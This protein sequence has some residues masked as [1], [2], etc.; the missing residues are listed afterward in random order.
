TRRITAD[1][2]HQRLAINGPNDEVRQ[3]GE[4]IDELLERLE[5]SFAAQ[6]RFVADASHELRTPLATMRASIDV[7]MA[8]PGPVPTATLALAGRLHTAL[9]RVDGLLD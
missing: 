5:D 2:L 9:D 6:R 7:A 4:T 1:N 8:K 3:L